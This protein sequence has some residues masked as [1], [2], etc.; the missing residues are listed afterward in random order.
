M[1]SLFHK[2]TTI[3]SLV[4]LP[5][6]QTQLTQDVNNLVLAN[7]ITKS[8]GFNK[9]NMKPCIDGFGID[10]FS[11]LVHEMESAFPLLSSIKNHPPQ[12][13]S[14]RPVPLQALPKTVGVLVGPERF[15]PNKHIWG[16]LVED[17]SHPPSSHMSTLWQR[18]SNR[19]TKKEAHLQHEVWCERMQ[20]R[21]HH[22]S[23]HRPSRPTRRPS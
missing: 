6:Q 20:Q 12:H 22:P 5:S 21:H 7:H 2:Q 16:V 10:L 14:K 15:E 4:F 8:D 3:H 13:P 17:A 18:A 19:N 1:V 23:K 11:C 9:K